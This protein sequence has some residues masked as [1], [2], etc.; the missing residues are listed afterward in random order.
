MPLFHNLLFHTITTVAS[1]FLLVLAFRAAANGG[2][3]LTKGRVGDIPRM[4]IN[5]LV[6]TGD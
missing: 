5:R 6:T 2:R 3:E 1:I 4:E